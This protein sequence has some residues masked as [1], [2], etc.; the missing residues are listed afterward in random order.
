MP[1]FVSPV[2]TYKRVLACWV[3]PHGAWKR[4]VGRWVGVGGVWR[5]KFTSG[6]LQLAP[7]TVRGFCYQPDQSSASLEFRPD[8]QLVASYTDQTLY[9]SQSLANWFSPT[10]GAVGTGFEIRAV[11]IAGMREFVTGPT[12]DTWLPLSQA[13]AWAVVS[14]A[15]RVNSVTACTL[16]ISIRPVGSVD[17][18]VTAQYALSATVYTVGNA[19]SSYGKGGGIDRSAADRFLAL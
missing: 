16:E 12:L 15:G 3:S 4:V 10:A 2:K 9:K 8:G 1:Y 14:P 17:P 5:K 6:V 7:S 18:A 13:R 11:P 19:N